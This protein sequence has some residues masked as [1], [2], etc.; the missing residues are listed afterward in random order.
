MNILDRNEEI[1]LFYGVYDVKQLL[2]NKAHLIPCIFKNENPW[3]REI[4][5]YKCLEN[6][7]SNLKKMRI[8]YL[9]Y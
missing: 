1:F 3:Q 7:I 8:I 2:S 9:A 6:L 5:I 4:Q